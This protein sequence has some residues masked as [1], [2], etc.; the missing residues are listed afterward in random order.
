MTGN[1]SSIVLLIC[2]IALCV[3]VDAWN[4]RSRHR[5]AERRRL[6]QMN[7]NR[8]AGAASLQGTTRRKWESAMLQGNNRTQVAREKRLTVSCGGMT[9]DN[10][11]YFVNPNYPSTFDGMDSCQV[12]LVKSI[13]TCVSIGTV[14]RNTFHINKSLSD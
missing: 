10:N 3:Q 7:N 11:T 9:A 13:R 4:D 5:L 1:R 2:C 6:W 12:T 14:F 8:P